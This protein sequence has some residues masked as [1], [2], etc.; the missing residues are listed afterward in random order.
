MNA[1]INRRRAEVRRLLL[2]RR[3]ASEVEVHNKVEDILTERFRWTATALGERV[4]LTFKERCQLGIRTIACVDVS[5]KMVKEY[6]LRRKRER[7]RRRARAMRAQI[8]HAR[9]SRRAKQL[10]AVLK[11]DWMPSVFLVEVFR[12]R[13]GWPR[14]RDAAGKA[15]RRAALELSKTDIEYEVKTE[16]GPRG[17][18]LTFVRRSPATTNIPDNQNPRSADEMTASR[19]G[20]S[21]LSVGQRPPDKN[22]SPH[23]RNRGKSGTTRLSTVH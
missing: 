7:D 3:A 12:K 16:P 13:N 19:R 18:Y 15:V 14:K 4:R 23:R 21:N 8:S 5:K 20:D 10:A 1:L 17:G 2:H 9:I 11:G 6:Y 22:V